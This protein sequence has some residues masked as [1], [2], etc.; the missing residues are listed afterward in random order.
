MTKFIKSYALEIYT[1]ISIAT[2][3]IAG[4][5][6]DLSVIQKFVLVYIFL[7]V[8]HKWEEMRYPGG[9][10]DLIARMLGI[11]LS[12]D[13]KKASRIPTSIL[14]LTFTLTPLFL[15]R[16]SLTVLPLA[17]LGL[18]EGVV[19]ILAIKLFKCPK[20]YS[21]GFVTAEIQTLV[22][23][24][25]FT[26]LIKHNLVSGAELVLGAVMMIACFV[27]MQRTLTLMIG[28]K[29]SDVFKNIRKQWKK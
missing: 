11:E 13:M 19:H 15:H 9:F 21:P 5:I 1:V 26:Y 8:M 6:G 29:Y 14:L 17:F 3:V 18:F 23:V 20:F 2:L 16:Y 28:Y 27:I 25:L 12:A 7:F 4:I 10:A 24:I 22:S